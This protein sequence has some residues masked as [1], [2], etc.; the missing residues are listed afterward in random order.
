M[1][2][3][4]AVTEQESRYV[5][6]QRRFYEELSNAR[7][8]AA[9]NSV[10]LSETTYR[11]LL[12]DALKAKKTA[13]K[14]PRD[15]WLLNRY[16][17][18][19][20]KSKLIYPVREGVNAIRF[21]VP[22]SELF[23]VLHE[24][25]LAVGHGGRDRML[26]ELSPKYKNITRYDIEL[27]LQI[28]EPCQKKQKG[29]KKGVAVLPMVFS[30]FNLRCQVDLID[31]QSHPDGEYKLIM[32]YQG[33][34][35]K[36]VALK[37][38]TAEEVAHNRVDMFTL[39]GAPSILQSDDGRE[40]ANKVVTSLKQHWP[41]LKIVH[42]KPRHSQSQGSVERANQDIENMLCTWTQDK[43]TDRWSDGLRFVQLTKNRAFHTG[44]KRTPYEALFGCKAKV[45]LATSSLPQDVLQDIQTEEELEEIIE[46]V[47][48]IPR[49]ERDSPLQETD[50]IAQEKKNETVGWKKPKP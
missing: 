17:V 41:S 18:I 45:G 26:K 9:K 44:I 31:F 38:K 46:S 34:L 14:E 10:F 4:G 25:H 15:Y 1:A 28:C 3:Q 30:N 22:D 23:D 47:Q 37:S 35:T 39:L 20:N 42:G 40:F 16:D 19:G 50:S 29:A 49:E 27:Y 12:S 11:N 7:T 2:E 33:H 8:S 13:K 36:F 48:T 21:Y 5:D 32:T 43:K 6:M 24:A